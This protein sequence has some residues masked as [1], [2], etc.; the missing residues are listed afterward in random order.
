MIQL[1]REKREPNTE[2]TPVTRIN[3]ASRRERQNDDDCL[4]PEHRDEKQNALADPFERQRTGSWEKQTITRARFGDC[5][6]EE[7]QQRQAEL[8][9]DEGVEIG[10]VLKQS[11]RLR[12]HVL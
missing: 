7:R 4:I 8:T 6:S 10:L 2:E 5:S 3:T 9:N 1:G 11:Q 12:V